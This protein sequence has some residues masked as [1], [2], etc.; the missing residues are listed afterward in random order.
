MNGYSVWNQICL[1]VGFEKKEN[2]A[3]MSTFCFGVWFVSLIMLV[4]LTAVSAHG[5][6]FGS[7]SDKKFVMVV[8]LLP[9]MCMDEVK[10]RKT[11]KWRNSCSE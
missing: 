6:L 10:L 5:H 3:C 11:H 4:C 7:W 8:M 9:K 2:Y 1:E